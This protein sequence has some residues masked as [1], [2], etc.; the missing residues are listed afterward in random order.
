MLLS[1]FSDATF[2]RKPWAILGAVLAVCLLSAFAVPPNDGY[3]TDVAGVLSSGEKARITQTLTDYER[4]TSNQIAVLIIP[5]LSGASI[6]EVGVEVGRSWGVGGK[7]KNNGILLLI[8]MNDRE[9]AILTGYG[10][11]GAV[12][13]IVAKGII[14]QDITPRFREGKYAD[15]IL[16]GI[17]ALE[18]HIGGEYTADRYASNASPS[19][20]GPF[21]VFLLFVC[22]NFAGS[23]L[24]R[25]KSWWLGGVLGGILGIVLTAL[26]SWWLSIP[27]LVLL[28]LFFDYLVSKHPEAFRKGRRGGGW[29]WGGRGGGFG[30]GSGGGGFG[31]FG[32]GS[33]GGG[34]AS[35]KW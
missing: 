16:A 12:P 3:V 11:E 26:F 21:V 2:F 25:S 29:W 10:L 27:G 13:D 14:D 17:D 7:Q 4:Q 22:V 20:I 24:A 8:S 33:F 30:G 1:T 15:G 18:K 34:G 32:G 28:G 35:G 9:M 6:N 31:G 19:A 5:S 23:F